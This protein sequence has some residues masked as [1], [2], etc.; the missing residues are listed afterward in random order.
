[1]LS[2]ENYHRANREAGEAFNMRPE[3]FRTYFEIGKRLSEPQ[4]PY[5]E[6]NGI[7]AAEYLHKDKAKTMFEEMGFQRDLEQL[8]NLIGEFEYGTHG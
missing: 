6:L 5:S 4:S 8:E 3:L 2:S 7:G 1:M